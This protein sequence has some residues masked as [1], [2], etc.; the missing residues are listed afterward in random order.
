MVTP[1]SRSAA[2]HLPHVPPQLDVDA[3][4]GLVEEQDLRLVRQRLRDHHATLHAARQRH[5]LV[6]LLVPQRQVA[7]H[8]FQVR[9][10][11][12]LAEQAAAELH[13]RPDALERV[14]GQLL[15]HQPD[16]GARRAEVAHDVVPVGRDLAGGRV[17][18]AADDVDQRRLAG[19]VRPEQREDLA[20]ADLEVDAFERL[21]ARGI[22]L[23]QIDDGD[24]RL[25]AAGI[26]G[27]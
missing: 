22:G 3:G 10:V 18:D 14:G 24:D 9:R 12:R 2:H 4:G 19:A 13:R 16:F 21:E 17:D 23:D 11:R 5:D 7:Q 15:R 27:R 26:I 25:H 20:A 6:V 8:L 1:L